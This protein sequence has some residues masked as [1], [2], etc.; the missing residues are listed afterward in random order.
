[1]IEEDPHA[2]RGTVDEVRVM[3]DRWA[4]LYETGQFTET[5]GDLAGYIL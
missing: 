2:F 4:A 3:L 1:V 5:V